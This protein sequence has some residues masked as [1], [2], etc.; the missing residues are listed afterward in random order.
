MEI[1]AVYPG[2]FDPVTNGHLDLIQRSSALF[3]SVVVAILRNADKAPLFTVE[4]RMEMLQEVVCEYK[5]VSITSFEGLTVDFVER[6]GASVII[7]GIRAVSD[8]EYELQMA[9]MNRR[10]SNKVETVFMLPAESYS[11]LSSKLVKEIA[12]H[13]GAIQGFVPKGVERRLSSK[14]RDK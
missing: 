6:I 10:L 11:F 12:H 1:R 14:F 3:D 5:N 7:R 4:E 9:L 13:G 2:S 8:Y